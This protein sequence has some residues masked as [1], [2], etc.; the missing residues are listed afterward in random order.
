MVS[1]VLSRAARA[2]R[3]SD[4]RYESGEDAG[5]V[6]DLFRKLDKDHDGRIDR[7][8]FSGIGPGEA[9]VSATGARAAGWLAKAFEE[10]DMDGDG[11]LDGEEVREFVGRVLAKDVFKFV[12]FGDEEPVEEEEEE[13]AEV[14]AAEAVADFFRQLDDDQDGIVREEEVVKAALSASS[15]ASVDLVR[16][17]FDRADADRDGGLDRIEAEVFLQYLEAATGVPLLSPSNPALDA[18]EDEEDVAEEYEGQE[19]PKEYEGQEEPEEYD[20]EAEES[21]EQHEHEV[22]EDNEEPEEDEEGAE[23]VEPVDVPEAQE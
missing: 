22:D 4:P 10:A 17:L 1:L 9:E 20:E 6:A 21:A 18:E 7:A 13:D 3:A 11:A 14:A 8:E 23:V 5:V 19:E 2:E 15:E 16:E 12:R